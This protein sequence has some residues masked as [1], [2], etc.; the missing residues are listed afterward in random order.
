MYLLYSLRWGRW[1][2]G[3]QH[4][5]RVNGFKSIVSGM[6]G[7]WQG[8]KNNLWR[9]IWQCHQTNSTAS[10]V[11]H[12]QLLTWLSY[13]GHWRF[14]NALLIILLACKGCVWCVCVTVCMCLHG[15]VF[16]CVCVCVCVRACVRA[17]YICSSIVLHLNTLI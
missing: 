7:Y 5:I 6:A 13:I 15:C 9:C 1:C 17:C 10:S 14:V 3:N 16:A 12:S 11:C 8:T 4:S 2:H